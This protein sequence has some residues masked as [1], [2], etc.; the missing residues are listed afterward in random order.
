MHF[1]LPRTWTWLGFVC[2]G[3]GLGLVWPG[4][5]L[6]LGLVPCGLGLELGLGLSGLD[7]KSGGKAH[8][9]RF[10]QPTSVG[11]G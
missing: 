5:G 6:G 7:Y 9:C 2:R 1:N 8:R 3:L 10:P 11:Q 4:L